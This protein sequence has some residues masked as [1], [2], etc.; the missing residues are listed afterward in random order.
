MLVTDS[1]LSC[2]RISHSLSHHA[3]L[4]VS[5][6]SRLWDVGFV[7]F[8]FIAVLGRAYQRNR[9][10]SVLDIT[11]FF[12]GYQNVTSMSAVL[13]AL[14]WQCTE[15][16]LWFLVSVCLSTPVRLCYTICVSSE[17]IHYVF[18]VAICHLC[19]GSTSWC[20]QAGAHTARLLGSF[21]AEFITALVRKS[22]KESE[23]HILL[24]PGWMFMS[25]R[26]LAKPCK[27]SQLG[28]AHEYS[29]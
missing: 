2:T 23:S 22:Y 19:K 3:Y 18:T 16:S 9:R 14:E 6:T 15:L 5:G 20:L 28:V 12:S 10:V 27:K 26:L 11:N 21:L 29:G 7:H 13:Y 17:L 8:L 1:G 24:P 25:D 4:Y